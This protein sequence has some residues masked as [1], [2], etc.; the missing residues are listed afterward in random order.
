M[1]SYIQSR[2]NIT[3]I[4][5]LPFMEPL[6]LVRLIRSVTTLI[7]PISSSL[8]MEE[9]ENRPFIACVQLR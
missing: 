1:N 2:T 4:S 8:N 3:Q 7:G 6:V 5:M 9:P